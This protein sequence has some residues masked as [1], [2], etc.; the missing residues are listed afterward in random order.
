MPK[1]SNICTPTNMSLETPKAPLT[2]APPATDVS[3]LT[4]AP[5]ATDVS[6]ATDAPL[7]LPATDVSPATDAPPATDVSPA[8][9]APPATDVLPA[10][11]APPATDV[12]PAT[13]APPA[14]DVSPATD[15]PL[16]LPATDVSSAPPAI[17][18]AH[19][20]P[21]APLTDAA[22]ETLHKRAIEATEAARRA[23]EAAL[24]ADAE[25]KAAIAAYRQTLPGILTAF[26]A[27]TT[28][29]KTSLPLSDLVQLAISET[30]ALEVKTECMHIILQRNDDACN[31]IIDLERVNR[32]LF[33]KLAEAKA[34]SAE[35]TQ[36]VDDI[37]I[38]FFAE[39][40]GK[41]SSK[42]KPKGAPATAPPATAPPATA[43][44]AT[45]PTPLKNSVATSTDLPFVKP[46]KT[47]VSN[48]EKEVPQAIFIANMKDAVQKKINATRKLEE[49]ADQ[50]K[51]TVKHADTANRQYEPTDISDKACKSRA[52]LACMQD[53]L[54]KITR[55]I[56]EHKKRTA[57]MEQCLKCVLTSKNHEDICQAI[58]NFIV[59]EKSVE[60]T[61]LSASVSAA[62]I[63]K[64]PT[65]SEAANL[66]KTTPSPQHATPSSTSKP[67]DAWTLMLDNVRLSQSI[68]TDDR[69]VKVGFEIPLPFANPPRKH[70]DWGYTTR[71]DIDPV[72]GAPVTDTMNHF[73]IAMANNNTLLN[74]ALIDSRIIKEG[75]HSGAGSP[76]NIKWKLLGCFNNNK[77]RR[78]I[79][80]ACALQLP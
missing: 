7:A 51:D 37:T 36:Q 24:K 55:D 38:R 50:L 1:I 2:D 60:T 28:D 54:G 11:D 80:I 14:T 27:D 31:K 56:A 74:A 21:K 63:V 6:P 49:K 40:S 79:I 78:L 69:G 17:D 48:E 25:C 75:Y 12:S 42:K 57:A 77:K 5:P 73:L 43:P 4:D 39:D 9:D 70:W 67:P 13:D 3:P 64:Y 46:D 19:E 58:N 33:T 41:S 8:T 26:T 16:A 35:L 59:H 53:A 66:M 68:E 20:T 23:T 45:A 62:D 44:S 30:S 34:K 61:T 52:N 18:A 10:T 32:G 22:H 71:D 65:P 72:S 76:T 15:A 29:G 47:P